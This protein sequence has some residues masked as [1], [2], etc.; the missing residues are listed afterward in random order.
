MRIAVVGA[1]VAG[2]Y[3][4]WRLARTHDVTLYEANDYAGGHTNTVDVE[5]GGRTWAVDTGFIVFN[6]W[7]YP[8]FIAMLDELRVGWQPSNM[9]FSLRCERTGLEYNG[10][11]VNSL[12]AQRRNLVRPAFLRMIADILRFNSR[13]KSLVGAA[14]HSLTLGEY[15]SAGGYSRQ[16]IEHFILPMGRAIW[17]AEATAMLEF[18]V[19]F[20]VEFFDRHGFLSVDDRPVWRTVRGGSREYVRALLAATRARVELATP[21]ESIRRLPDRVVLRTARGD[22]ESFE[23]VFLACHADQALA[24]LEAPTAAES[25]VLGALPYAA[26]EAILHTDASLL[27]RRPLARAAWNY[28]LLADPQEPV[29]VTYDMNVLQSLDAPCRFLVTLN[30]RRAIDERRILRSFSYHHPVYHPRGVAAQQRHRE[31]NGARRTYFCGAYWRSGFHEDGVV[32]AQAA[33][34]HFDEDLERAQLPL[35]RVG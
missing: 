16:F 9:S 35:Q 24:M 13:A 12:F 25:E 3:A 17:S 22:N 34:G 2:L 18:P 33:L 5:Y 32:S 27:P 21:V 8:N 23:H 1:G 10:T 19:R 6:D 26:N 30:H 28:H 4:A 31:L 29:A 14:D 20:F 15:L 11:S 7:T